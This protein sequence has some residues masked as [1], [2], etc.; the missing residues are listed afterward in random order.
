MTLSLPDSLA[1]M[2]EDPMLMQGVFALAEKLD[3]SKMV[4]KN[5][6][7]AR[8]Y[9]EALTMA[10]VARGDY[11]VLMHDLWDEIFCGATQLGSID[12]DPSE[13]SPAAVWED[14]DLCKTLILKTP[15][16]SAAHLRLWISYSLEE[17]KIL[18]EFAAYDE[19]DDQIPVPKRLTEIKGWQLDDK[20]EM[21]HPLL[22]S[23][24][25]SSEDL[26]ASIETGVA[27]AT[28]MFAACAEVI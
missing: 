2:Q 11:V 8:R 13:N 17:R 23:D 27:L 25:L 22:V 21:D 28:Q 9:A 19:N 20:Y 14:E 6:L 10:A 4:A 3:G 1:A 16:G 18:L 7:E 26:P 5:W 24:Q 12:P 15:I